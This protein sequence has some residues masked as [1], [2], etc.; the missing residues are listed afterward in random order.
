MTT[1]M[2][3]EEDL[4]F[5]V[6]SLEGFLGGLPRPLL[7]GG[8]DNREESVLRLFV[9]GF[10]LL[11]SLMNGASGASS[12][13]RGVLATDRDFLFLLPGGRPR[14]ILTRWESH[15][16]AKCQNDNNEFANFP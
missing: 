13:G 5:G 10:F 3:F 9:S 8:G 6:P 16:D 2:S 11:I 1:F 12:S 4:A 15:G 14:G 7:A